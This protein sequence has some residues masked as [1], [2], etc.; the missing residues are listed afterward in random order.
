MGFSEH[1]IL[2]SPLGNTPGNYKMNQQNVTYSITALAVFHGRV[3]AHSASVKNNENSL[4]RETMARIPV[5]LSGQER[6]LTIYPGPTS[7]C[8]GCPLTHY[9]ALLY[10]TGISKESWS[11]QHQSVHMQIQYQLHQY[12]VKFFFFSGTGCFC[13]TKENPWSYM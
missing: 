2:S 11:Y 6:N 8:P 7:V 4:S 13:L 3:M 1:G 10:R 5:R 12:S 9:E